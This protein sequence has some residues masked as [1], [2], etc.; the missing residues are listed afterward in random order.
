MAN[1]NLHIGGRNRLSIIKRIGEAYLTSNIENGEYSYQQ[2]IDR[3]IERHYKLD[4]RFYDS[5]KKIA[6]LVETKRK[7]SKKD[8][9]QLFA[10]VRLEQELSSDLPS[11]QVL[12]MQEF[13]YG[14]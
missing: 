9:S 5:L 8:K 4:I 2:V 1:N 10:Y 7:I 11:L 13:R 6:V 12:K 14:K 3:K